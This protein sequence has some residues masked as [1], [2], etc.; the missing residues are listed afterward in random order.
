VKDTVVILVAIG[1]LL[2]F[3]GV[4]VLVSTLAQIKLP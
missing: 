1:G 3:Y 2:A 4:V